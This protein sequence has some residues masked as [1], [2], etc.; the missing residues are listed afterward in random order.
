MSEGEAWEGD[1]KDF[2]SICSIDDALGLS[3]SWVYILS[4][5]VRVENTDHES[6]ASRKYFGRISILAGNYIPCSYRCVGGFVSVCE[7]DEFFSHS[8]ITDSSW[9]NQ[10][11][12]WQLSRENLKNE[13]LIF[14][15]ELES[16]FLKWVQLIDTGKS[17]K[18][19]F[20]LCVST[21]ARLLF[22]QQFQVIVSYMHMLIVEKSLEA[23]HNQ[24]DSQRSCTHASSI[25][26]FSYEQF[27]TDIFQET[28]LVSPTHCCPYHKE[29][30]DR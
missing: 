9:A 23:E 7:K 4:W 13:F 18:Y 5:F 6:S 21:K 28:G 27:L 19:H 16:F 11:Q 29:L 25:M 8:W 14:P 10:R 26:N 24:H 30:Y 22:C 15:A 20:L 17:R 2:E 1:S 12:R 3:V